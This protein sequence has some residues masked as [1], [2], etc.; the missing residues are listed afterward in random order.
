MMRALFRVYWAVMLLLFFVYGSAA[1]GLWDPFSLRR[2]DAQPTPGGPPAIQV[3][4]PTA[5]SGV[6][7][8][9]QITVGTS[10]TQIRAATA[11]RTALII[12]NH[13][14]TNVFVGFTNAV[15]ATT[16]VMLVGIPGQTLTFQTQSAIWAYVA[17]GSQVV[18]FYEELR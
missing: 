7:A 4:Q 2:A 11:N 6:P 15:N 5:S 12:V 18:G 1:I 16:G 8:H 17:S 13:G 10:A 14:S 9:G 3:V